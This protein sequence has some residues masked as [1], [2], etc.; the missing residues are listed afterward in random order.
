MCLFTISV[1]DTCIIIIIACLSFASNTGG[2]SIAHFLI[3]PPA[4][5]TPLISRDTVFISSA[6]AVLTLNMGGY[7]VN[8][9]RSNLSHAYIYP[10]ELVLTFFNA[11]IRSVV[12]DNFPLHFF[13]LPT[14]FT[15]ISKL[16]SL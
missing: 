13:S 16:P 1:I 6:M 4:R 8:N 3:S 15:P 7:T 12:N 11:Q 10:V 5:L 9:Q 2:L 14:E